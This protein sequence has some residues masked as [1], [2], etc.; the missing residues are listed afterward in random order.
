MKELKNYNKNDYVCLLS[1]RGISNCEK[2]IH[3]DSCFEYCF[4][5]GRFY[6]NCSFYIE[7]S[8]HDQML[9]EEGF[10]EYY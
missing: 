7:R 5:C 2:I 9:R 1:A 10:P 4:N 3:S 8:K 6:Q